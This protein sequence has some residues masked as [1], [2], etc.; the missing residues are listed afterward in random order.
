[1]KTIGHIDELGG[2]A[3]LVAGFAHAAFQH[4]VDVQLLANFAKD[5]LFVLAL[6]REG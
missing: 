2:D 1:M 6:E 3:Q 5:V 4:R